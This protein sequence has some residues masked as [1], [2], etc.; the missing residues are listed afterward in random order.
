MNKF[1]YKG[2]YFET[3]SS[4]YMV[5]LPPPHKYALNLYFPFLLNNHTKNCFFNV[6]K[7][8][9]IYSVYSCGGFIPRSQILC[10]LTFILGIKKKPKPEQVIRSW[11]RLKGIL[12]KNKKAGTISCKEG[13]T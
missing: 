7:Y 3:Q 13:L 4:S 5:Y 9:K 2:Y 12:F 10:T 8:L 6:F 11:N 1:F